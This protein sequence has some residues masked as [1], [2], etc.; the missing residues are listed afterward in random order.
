MDVYRGQLRPQSGNGLL[1]SLFK[2]L[3]RQAIPILK[4]SAPLIKKGV[5]RLA[6]HVAAAGVNLIGDLADKKKRDFKQVAK[7]RARE[8]I[9]NTIKSEPAKRKRQSSVKRPSV[10]KGRGSRRKKDIFD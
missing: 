9:V 10:S 3:S 4:K 7:T 8:M 2:V 5:K 1:G 6:P